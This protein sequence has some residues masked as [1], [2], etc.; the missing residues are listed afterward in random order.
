MEI[1]PFTIDNETEAD[2][3]LTDLLK[4]PE[5]QYMDVIAQRCDRL[6][7]NPMI[8]A[9]FLTTGAQMLADMKGRS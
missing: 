2:A 8:R 9:Y 5:F 1:T 7:K 3:Y 4:R 6:V